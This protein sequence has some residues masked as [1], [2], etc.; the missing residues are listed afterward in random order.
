MNDTEKARM[1]FMKNWNDPRFLFSSVLYGINY[2]TNELRAY[3]E[4]TQRG[5]CL[6]RIT[7][8]RS[9]NEESV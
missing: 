8:H 6:P 4:S 7:R 2:K 5:Q 3:E 9:Q 1:H